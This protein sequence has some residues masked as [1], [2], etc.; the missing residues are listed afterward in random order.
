MIVGLVVLV[1]NGNKSDKA[2]QQSIEAMQQ[3]LVPLETEVNELQE[4]L[5]NL[6]KESGT[7]SVGVATEEL[8]VLE[9]DTELYTGLFPLLKKYETCGV[10]ALSETELPGLP[11]K[12]TEQQ[13]RNLINQGWS[14][15]LGWDG[16]TELSDWLEQMQEYLKELDLEMPDIVYF[17]SGSYSTELDAVLSEYGIT[18]AIHH[19]EEQLSIMNAED[20]NE[21]IWH[22]GA[23]TWN[24]S[25][26]KMDMTALAKSGMNMVFTVSFQQEE[27][28]YMEENFQSMLDYI[29]DFRENDQLMVTD[30]ATAR[31]A[32]IEA[33][34]E[35][36]S[37]QEK[38]EAE[39]EELQAEIADL[40]SQIK[41]IYA[42]GR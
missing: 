28:L 32:K 35:K 42:Q 29:A 37:R 12:I 2:R 26:V 3:E 10:L 11:D 33:E 13:F 36:A 34:A 1:W 40:E 16:T 21:E 25:G 23:K 14:Y 19:G 7:Q 31:S 8:L 15:C 24:Y 5:N 4:K 9:L 20:F 18:I 6:K 38:L 17:P 27:S 41:E 30:F 22:P 39:Q